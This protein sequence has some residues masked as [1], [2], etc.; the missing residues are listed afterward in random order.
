MPVL[1]GQGVSRGIAGGT[2]RFL[3][4][5]PQPRREVADREGEIARFEQ[6]RQ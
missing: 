4:N 1:Q 6:A 2:L 5:Q 3:R